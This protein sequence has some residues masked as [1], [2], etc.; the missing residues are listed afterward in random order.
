MDL[1]IRAIANSRSM[2]LADRR[3]D[4]QGWRG[5]L[6]G[7]QPFDL[8]SFLA[9]VQT[10]T[11][12]HAVI[13]DCTASDD[14]ARRYVGW[15]DRGIHVVT[16]NKKAGSADFAYY[17]EL[18]RAARAGSAHFLYETTVGAGLPILQ[19]LRDLTHYG[20]PVRRVEGVL[21]GTL[22]YL[23]NCSTAAAASRRSSRRSAEGLYRARSRDDLSGLDVA[24]KVVILAREMGLG[25]NSKMWT[26]PA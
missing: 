24:R 18:R 7:G 3:V 17:E 12:P 2:H 21:S 5:A 16:P 14:L 26:L 15:L 20:R 6:D 11:L 9:H 19:T 23:F 4:L 8:E 10:D 25:P 1:R 22:S 13:I